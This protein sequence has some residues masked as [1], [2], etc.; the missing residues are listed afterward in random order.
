[1]TLNDTYQSAR[2]SLEGGGHDVVHL[3]KLASL[4]HRLDA[5]HYD[6]SFAQFHNFAGTFPYYHDDDFGA[7]VLEREGDLNVDSPVRV[8]LYREA[9][10]RANWCAQAATAGGEGLS[11]AISF[12]R[13][14]QKHKEAE[15]VHRVNDRTASDRHS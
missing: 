14:M 4:L 9:M 7:L 6:V 13:L 2:K 10:W 8:R 15:Q 11:R 12:Q 3:E 1:M 5:R